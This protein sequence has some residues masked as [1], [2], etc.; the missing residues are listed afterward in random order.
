MNP[1]DHRWL[2]TLDLPGQTATGFLDF[3]P[4]VGAYGLPGSLAGKRCLDVG[5]LDGF[6]A[7]EMERRGGEVVAIDVDD[8]REL[9]WPPRRRPRAFPGPDQRGAGFRIAKERLGSRVERRS[10]PV[11]AATREELGAFDF[12]L[13]GS[14][15]GYLRDQF[16]AFER[17]TALLAPGASLVSAQPY[18]P[19]L[20]LLPFPAVRYV[21][22]EEPA[23]SF[24]SPSRRAW[25]HMIEDAGFENVTEHARVALTLPSG[26]LRMV[27]HHAGNVPAPRGGLR[28][29][30]ER[31]LT[32]APEPLK[33]AAKRLA[34]AA[35][36][37]LVPAYRRRGWYQGP[38]PPAVLRARVGA[39]VSVEAFVGGGRATVDAVEAALEAHGRSLAG[40]RHIYDWGCGCGRL[41]LHLD[42]RRSA[43]TTLSGSDV[44]DEAVAWAARAWP[45][46]RIAV[47]GFSPPL[48]VG[49]G[50]VDCLISSSILTHLPEP[51]QDAWLGEIHRV[52]APGGIALVSVQ[53]RTSRELIARGEHATRGQALVDALRALPELDVAGFQFVPYERSERTSD[54]FRGIAGE[55]GMTFHSPAYVREHWSRWFDVLD[56][57]EADVNTH[58]DL[59]VVERGSEG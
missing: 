36:A 51:D 39:G 16:L 37:V 7:F 8:A 50:E 21:A 32:L 31:A 26:S 19:R 29:R 35:D 34:P 48:P 6:W 22:H 3:R 59:V 52:L 57:R 10:L 9:D 49:D 53:G 17:L 38:I 11:Y 56:H 40:L 15:L 5:T 41:L 44:D 4:H 18:E 27:I 23:V 25:L 2:Q 54:D 43:H 33:D 13:C 28:A 46:M 42:R 47:N 12:V 58:Q 24:W 1:A 14:G 55:Y 30:A 45:H 20:D